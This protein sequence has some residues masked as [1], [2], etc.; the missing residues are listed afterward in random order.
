[1]SSKLGC[2]LLYRHFYDSWATEGGIVPQMTIVL[3]ILIRACFVC[4]LYALYLPACN[5]PTTSI[6]L[7][8]SAA[9]T[10]AQ[11]YTIVRSSGRP[12]LSI[13]IYSQSEI[14]NRFHVVS[15]VP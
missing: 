15:C 13:D 7:L 10:A 3:L 14:T 8:R 6:G 1:M 4:T 9:D 2:C 5:N 12:M 11:K